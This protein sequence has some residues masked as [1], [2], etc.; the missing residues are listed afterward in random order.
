MDNQHIQQPHKNKEE[1]VEVGLFAAW[2]YW[3]IGKVEAMKTWEPDYES[4]GQVKPSTVM[5]H[6]PS[7]ERGGF[8]EGYGSASLHGRK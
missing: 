4:P 8:L 1:K 5:H 6:N 2:G 7:T 3:S